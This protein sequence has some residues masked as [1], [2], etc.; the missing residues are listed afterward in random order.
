MRVKFSERLGK[1]LAAPKKVS[2][3]FRQT[4]NIGAIIPHKSRMYRKLLRSEHSQA[5]SNTVT[6]LIIGST[7]YCVAKG[8]PEVQ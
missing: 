5:D 1:T 6:H 7:F 4:I 8:V 3:V 2:N